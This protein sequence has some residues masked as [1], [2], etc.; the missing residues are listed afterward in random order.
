MNAISRSWSYSYV[1]HTF[2]LT[3]S[4]L[5]GIET[6]HIMLNLP[7]LPDSLE[8]YTGEDVR[9]PRL[10]VPQIRVSYKEEGDPDRLV[11]KGEFIEYNQET[12]ET[13]AI[14]PTLN[15]QIIHH[16]QSLSAYKELGGGNSESYYTP[17]ISMK[18]KIAPLFLTVAANGSRKTRLLLEG[19]IA[20]TGPL[21]TGNPDLRYQRHLYILHEGILK[22]LVVYGASFSSFI[23]LTKALAGQSSSS[24]TL[25]LSTTRQKTGAVVYYPIAFTIK[26]KLDTKATEPVLKELAEWFAKYDSLVAMQSQARSEQA[27][28]E[29]GDGPVKPMQRE[30][31][32]MQTS[33]PVEQ[34]ERGIYEQVHEDDEPR[35]NP[36]DIPFG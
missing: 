31:K 5:R 24:V 7:I 34:N 14:G 21:R 3:V 28:I 32:P 26:E 6:T 1:N 17:E 25:E 23:D 20:K 11:A 30:E 9:V 4:N 10:A 22:T 16:R 18:T 29:R 33:A 8:S 19:E 2:A 13:K 15:I 35:I 27:A 12:K 36:D